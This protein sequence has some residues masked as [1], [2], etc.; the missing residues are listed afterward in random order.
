MKKLGFIFVLTL[1]VNICATA[2]IQRHFFD[3]TL[4]VTT[5]KEVSKY[6][7]K[8]GKE[9]INIDDEY[10]VDNVKFAG[11]IWTCAAFYFHEGKL[12]R[13]IFLDNENSSSNQGLDSL[14]KR[15]S[16]TI[17]DKYSSYY[18]EKVSKENYLVYDDDQTI[19]VLHYETFEGRKSIS[20]MYNDRDLCDKVREEMNN[21]L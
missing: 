1:F 16:N 21:D 20:I 18:N 13:V 8:N 14:W 6:F 11:N 19:V 2:Q 3:F 10:I 4:G 17:S 7:E 12:M 15:L 9:L 5:Q